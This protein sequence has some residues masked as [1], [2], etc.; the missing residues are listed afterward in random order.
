MSTA[1]S[2]IRKSAALSRVEALSLAATLGAEPAEP[3][4]GEPGE[5][6]ERALLTF[7]MIPVEERIGEWRFAGTA[8]SLGQALSGIVDFAVAMGMT[9]QSRDIAL[10]DWLEQEALEVWTDVSKAWSYE[11]LPLDEIG[12]HQVVLFAEGQAPYDDFGFCVLELASL[13]GSPFRGRTPD[14]SRPQEWSEDPDVTD[15]DVIDDE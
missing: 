15:D 13:E 7:V 10:R 1:S 8:G 6:A 9:Q 2:S 5:E 12:D 4:Q 3:S 14:T 11:S